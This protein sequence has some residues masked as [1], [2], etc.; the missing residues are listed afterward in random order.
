MSAGTC[1]TGCGR[2]VRAGH[3]MCGACWREVPRH[4]QRDVHRTWRAFCRAAGDEEFIAYEM[5]REA[6]IASVP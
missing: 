4:L 1:P 2:S 3:L 5:A 6:A